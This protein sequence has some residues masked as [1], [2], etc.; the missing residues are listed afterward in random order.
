MT[1]IKK[2]RHRPAIKLATETGDSAIHFL[3]RGVGHFDDLKAQLVQ[4]IGNGMRV[5]N[6]IAQ[7]RSADI[8][9]IANHQG[10][11]LR[12][13]LPLHGQIALRR[14]NS[15]R[16]AEATQQRSDEVYIFDFIQ[17]IKSPS[18]LPGRPGLSVVT[19]TNSPAQSRSHKF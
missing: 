10:H 6:R 12:L 14:L 2:Q 17:H 3:L 9:G 15:T 16:Q 4:L 7:R 19:Q 5:V 11:A 18:S 8:S 13:L 1:R